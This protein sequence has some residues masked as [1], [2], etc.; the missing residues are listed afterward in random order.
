MVSDL[1]PALSTTYTENVEFCFAS[2]IVTVPSLGTVYVL[3]SF[4][5]VTYAVFN[6]A[7][8]SLALITN[9]KVES[10][11]AVAVKLSIVG[12]FLSILLITTDFFVMLPAASLT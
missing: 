3:V 12:T 7:S 8:L 1:F 10:E 5:E 2:V 6:P 11:F 4:E 9:L